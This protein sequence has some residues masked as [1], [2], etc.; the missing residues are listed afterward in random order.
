[1]QVPADIFVPYVQSRQPCLH[2][3]SVLHSL[4]DRSPPKV[5][6]LLR[7]VFHI[8]H[9]H[10]HAEGIAAVQQGNKVFRVLDDGTRGILL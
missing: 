5:P 7:A 8:A 2:G 10:V 4:V 1:M 9:H 3:E 6:F